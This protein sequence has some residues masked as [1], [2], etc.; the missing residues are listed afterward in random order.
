[1]PPD[2]LLVLPSRLVS[3][4]VVVAVSVVLD[5]M[6]AKD[7]LRIDFQDS[8]VFCCAVLVVGNSGLCV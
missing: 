8:W 6:M 2:E 3:V 5:M 1:L 4:V 7:E